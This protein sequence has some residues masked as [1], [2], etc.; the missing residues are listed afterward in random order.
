MPWK[1]CLAY[2][3]WTLTTAQPKECQ[4]THASILQSSQSLIVLNH[5]I[6]FSTI[7]WK[8]MVQKHK[9]SSS[10]LWKKNS[11][12]LLVKSDLSYQDFDFLGRESWQWCPWLR[13]SSVELLDIRHDWAVQHSHSFLDHYCKLHPHLLPSTQLQH[14]W[15]HMTQVKITWKSH[16]SS[17][18]EQFFRGIQ[19]YYCT[20]ECCMAD[21]WSGLP[22]KKLNWLL[23]QCLSN[24]IS[25]AWARQK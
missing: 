12:S 16:G 11:N 15:Q 10:D 21:K 5:L 13:G 25:L 9:S 8:N 20:Y 19:V 6:S 3:D 22:N 14:Q 1:Y 17:T 24:F 23:K 18:L 2:L 7:T 4:N